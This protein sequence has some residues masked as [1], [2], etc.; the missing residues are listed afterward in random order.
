MPVVVSLVG[1]FSNDIGDGMS[2]FEVFV[3]VESDVVC[4]NFVCWWWEVFDG[5]F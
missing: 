5:M 3:I 1:M 2:N 4:F